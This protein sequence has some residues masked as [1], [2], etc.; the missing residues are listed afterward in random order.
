MEERDP[1]A[2]ESVEVAD[3]PGRNQGGK[4]ANGR[5]K[6]PWKNNRK[7]RSAPNDDP[8]KDNYEARRST[9]VDKKYSQSDGDSW[10]ETLAVV[11]IADNKLA[12]RSFYTNLRTKARSWDEPPSGASRILSAT[13]EMRRMAQMQ[14]LE[15]QIATGHVP[16]IGASETTPQPKKG[17][18]RRKKTSDAASKTNSRK[19]VYK[20]SS[21]MAKTKKATPHMRDETL[22]P[23][24]QK[25]IALSM[26]TAEDGYSEGEEEKKKTDEP[27]I[28]SEITYQDDEEAMAMVMALSLSEAESSRKPTSV[29]PSEEEMLRRALEA[30]QNELVATAP[31][32]ASVPQEEDLLGI[33][34]VSP[35][36]NPE[37]RK[38]P[39]KSPP[40]EDWMNQKMP[41]KPTPVRDPEQPQVPE[42]RGSKSRGRNGSSRRSRNFPVD[43]KTSDVA[44]L[45]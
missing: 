12:L 21:F 17:F 35:T 11:E 25:A 3:V 28:R 26:K 23:Q 40:D 13:E 4:E 29:P 6:L 34:D 39:P 1:L 43:P 10:Q 9:R 19:I 24:M 37:S 38:L 42:K 22:D 8:M 31:P 15:M 32:V 30:S 7:T 5:R 27:V 41:A 20:P 36:Q 14:L 2:E 45:L 33:Y 16:D 18:F 44:G